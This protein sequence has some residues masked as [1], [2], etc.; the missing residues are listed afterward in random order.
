MSEAGSSDASTDGGACRWPDS[1]NTFTTADASLA[2]CLPSVGG[3]L[4]A[5][6]QYTLTCHGASAVP[7]PGLQC[8]VVPI[9]T[10]ANVLYYCCPCGS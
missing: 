3:N 8:A 1:A 9:P 5:A 4:C 6:A 10:P 2:G 7:A